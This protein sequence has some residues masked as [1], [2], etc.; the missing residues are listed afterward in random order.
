[1]ETACKMGKMVLERALGGATSNFL[2]DSKDIKDIN[3]GA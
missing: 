3:D 2:Q 1:M